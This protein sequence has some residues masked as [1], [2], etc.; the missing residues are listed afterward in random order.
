ML[1]PQQ[2]RAFAEL[3]TQDGIA[4]R[5]LEFTILT[6]ARTGE[7]I[8]TRWWEINLAD[9]T[10]TIPAERMKAGAEHRVP[11]YDRVIAILRIM[12]QEQA[13]YPTSRS[14]VGEVNSH[15]TATRSRSPSW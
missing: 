12:E 1:G 9:K 6:A 13:V 8:G 7:A 11:L 5:A 10:W 4:A 15:M 3:R 2:N 14:P